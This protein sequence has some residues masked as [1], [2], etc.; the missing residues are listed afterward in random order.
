MRKVRRSEG[1]FTLIEL[2]IVIII[3][4]VLAAV[5]AFNVGGFLGQGTEETAKTEA[6]TVQ[7]AL[8]AGMADKSIGVVTGATLKN[9][10]APSFDVAYSGGTFDLATYL[11]LPTHGNWLFNNA[12]LVVAGAYE[13]GGTCCDYDKTATPQWN[14]TQ[15]ET[16]AGGATACS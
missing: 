3:L 16:C 15:G 13:G 4:G 11:H 1:G 7:T 14:C 10:D 2:L 9:S 12:G 5:V 6:L 8:L